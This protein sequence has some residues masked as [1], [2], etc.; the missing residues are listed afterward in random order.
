MRSNPIMLVIVLAVFVVWGYSQNE[1]TAAPVYQSPGQQSDALG[2]ISSDVSRLTEAVEAMNRS[3]K[4]FFDTFSSNQTGALLDERQ[5]AL[6]FALEVLNRLEQS[7]VNMQK[8]K[9]DLSE[10][11]STVRLKLAGVTDDLRPESI[12]RFT[13]WRGTTDAET[14]RDIRRQALIKEQ[15]ELST[16]LSQ[17][18]RELD[19][20]N[21]EIRKTELQ[22]ANIRER[23]FGEVEIQL[24]GF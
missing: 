18:T 12:D 7:L 10:R 5:R 14:V 17:I 1:R 23:I 24:A 2:R 19:Q 16:M 6:I 11:Q 8:L 3:W 15:R 13:A 4:R 22:I 9:L 20:T 21:G